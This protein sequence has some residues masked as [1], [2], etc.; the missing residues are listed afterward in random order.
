MDGTSEFGEM[1]GQIGIAKTSHNK[2]SPLQDTNGMDSSEW[3]DSSTRKGMLHDIIQYTNTAPPDNRAI[4]PFQSTHPR[5]NSI[6]TSITT[7]LV[8]TP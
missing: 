1:R 6:I 5:V 8:N 4:D 7:P 3:I 2:T